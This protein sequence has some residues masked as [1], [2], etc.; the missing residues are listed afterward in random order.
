MDVFEKEVFVEVLQKDVEVGENIYLY[1]LVEVL[2]LEIVSGNVGE[3]VEDVDLE[4][5]HGES[6]LILLRKQMT[7]PLV[8]LGALLI[9]QQFFHVLNQL[10]YLLYVSLWDIIVQ[11]LL[12]NFNYH[13][14]TYA[15]PLQN[16]SL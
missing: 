6:Q 13:V 5:L 9:L 2:L 7:P 12:Q 10:V 1:Y 3:S 14:L 15:R 8:S 4:M 11:K 16:D